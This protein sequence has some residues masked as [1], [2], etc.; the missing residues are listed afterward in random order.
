MLQ[1][2]KENTRKRYAHIIKSTPFKN[3]FHPCLFAS[4]F[5]FVFNIPYLLTI[6]TSTSLSLCNSHTGFDGFAQQLLPYVYFPLSRTVLPD[7]PFALNFLI[8]AT[9]QLVLFKNTYA[10]TYT[11]CH[12]NRSLVLYLIIII[13]SLY[14][15]NALVRSY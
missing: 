9:A 8:R 13:F 1:G 4:V 2:T 3:V 15:A 6:N 11:G 10:H 7:Y 14:F 5:F 12:V